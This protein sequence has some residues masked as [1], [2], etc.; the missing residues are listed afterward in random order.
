MSGLW[1]GDCF[2]G[3]LAVDFFSGMVKEVVRRWKLNVVDKF[4][5][6]LLER[7]VSMLLPH[8]VWRV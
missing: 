1:R 7:A 5:D 2:A 8:V 6:F 4:K 3:I